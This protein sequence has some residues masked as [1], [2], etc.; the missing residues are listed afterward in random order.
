MDV[1]RTQYERLRAVE[2]ILAKPVTEEERQIAYNE[3]QDVLIEIVKQDDSTT[4]TKPRIK[5]AAILKAG[6]IYTG[7]THAVILHNPSRPFGFLKGCPQGF[8]TDF[9]TFVSRE[10][11]AKIA[12]NCGQIPTLK[13]ELFSEDLTR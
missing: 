9:G 13:K 2:I 5:E 7:M 3:I 12:F 11:A 10:V 1:T 6:I 4:C 8:V